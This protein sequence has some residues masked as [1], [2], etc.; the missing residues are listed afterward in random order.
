MRDAVPYRMPPAG[1]GVVPGRPCGAG[2]VGVPRPR[3]A[4]GRAR[5]AGAGGRHVRRP[6]MAASAFSWTVAEAVHGHATRRGYPGECPERSAAPAGPL[7]GPQR[8][9]PGRGTGKAS[10]PPRT[11][12]V[13]GRWPRTEGCAAERGTGRGGGSGVR[14]RPREPRGCAH[15]PSSGNTL[16]APLTSGWSGREASWSG[17]GGR[18]AARP[19]RRGSLSACRLR[20]AT[21]REA[22]PTRPGSRRPWRGAPQRADVRGER[23]TAA[24]RRP[25][26]S[27]ECRPGRRNGRTGR[28]PSGAWWGQELQSRIAFRV[29]PHCRGGLG[30]SH[31]QQHLTA[32]GR[33]QSRLRYAQS[34]MP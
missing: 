18:A 26:G 25:A 3:R 33:S 2:G 10:P 20:T 34:G 15:R 12:A 13:S 31:L 16:R 30:V 8:V 27:R 32:P 21:S 23:R 6:P 9:R 24:P 11:P 1:S 28:A 22:G 19:R 4:F 29:I 14:E 7:N 5:S 17:R